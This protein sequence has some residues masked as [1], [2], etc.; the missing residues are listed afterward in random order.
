MTATAQ[1]GADAP[2]D[3]ADLNPANAGPVRDAKRVPMS[4]P[5]A[6]LAVPPIPGYYLHWF[7][8]EAGRIEHALRAGYEFVSDEEV[9]MQGGILGSD[10][11]ESRNT[12]MGSRV[13]MV[14]GGT[15][16]NGEPTRLYLMKLRKELREEDETARD[17]KAQ[18][19]IN[20][21]FGTDAYRR[22]TMGDA[23]VGANNTYLD[24]SRS[25][26]PEFFKR[27]TKS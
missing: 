13:S 8:N 24:R 2:S 20:S 12:D 6:K 15:N 18:Q 9:L 22:S 25:K 11:A 1:L 4:V 17:D 16:K 7:R 27:K 14:A 19:L 3:H 26:M 23:H 10:T 21:L 5:Q